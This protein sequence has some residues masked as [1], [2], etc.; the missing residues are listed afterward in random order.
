MHD[1]IVFDNFAIFLYLVDA[2]L[3]ILVINSE[4]DGYLKDVHFLYHK[5]QTIQGSKYGTVPSN[6][7][8][9]VGLPRENEKHKFQHLKFCARNTYFGSP[10]HN[11]SITIMAVS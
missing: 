7:V 3:C 2:I 8:P 5:V 10:F 11:P 4:L 9:L 1:I 6:T